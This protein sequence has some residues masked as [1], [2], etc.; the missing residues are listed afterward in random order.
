M[1]HALLQHGASVALPYWDWTRPV[2][3]LP[4][5]FTS[6]SYYDAWRDQVVVNPFTRCYIQA[7]DGFTVRDPQP[8]LYKLSRDGRHS[9]L[10]DEVLLALEQTDYCDFEVQYEVTHNAIHYLVGGRQTYALSSLEYTSYDPIFFVHHS[11]VDKIWVIWQE[12]QKKRGLTYDRA[13]CA[14]N[15]MNQPLHPFD[16]ESVNKDA[17]TREHA[18]PLTVFD[19]EDLGYHYD[20]LDM[21]G[22]TI[23]ELEQLIHERKSRARVFAGFYLKGIGTS[24]DV[25]FYACKT[26]IECVRAGGLFILGGKTEMPWAFDRLFK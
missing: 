21:G 11:F 13:D 12:L 17:M 26:D 9:V 16:W 5:L 7:V 3:E 20:N 14:V 18:L 22:Q 23:E 24:A 25:T 4:E 15:Y 6:E 2:T 10:F 8:E 1:E 19:K